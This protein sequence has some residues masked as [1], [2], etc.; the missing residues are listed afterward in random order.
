VAGRAAIGRAAIGR[1]AI[2]WAEIG[3]LQPV[4]LSSICNI[5]NLPDYYVI[6]RIYLCKKFIKNRIMIIAY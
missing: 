3:L 6:I 2:G 1:A 5:R 4:R